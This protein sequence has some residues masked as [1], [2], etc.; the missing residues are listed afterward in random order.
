[1]VWKNV[2]SALYGTGDVDSAGPEDSWPDIERVFTEWAFEFDLGPVVRCDHIP[3]GLNLIAVPPHMPLLLE[4]G[5]KTSK[6]WRGS[7]LFVLEDLEPL[8]EMDPRGFRCVRK[9]A[10]GLLK[11]VLNGVAWGGRPNQEG[12]LQKNVLELLH[13]DPEGMRLAG[14]LFGPAEKTVLAAAESFAG[15]S[16][17]QRSVLMTEGWAFLRA[18]AAPVTMI[19]RIRFRLTAKARCPIVSVLLGHQRRIPTDREAWLRT[20]AESHTVHMPGSTARAG[21]QS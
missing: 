16:W 12:L 14:R 5:V 1:M 13:A 2:E 9:G 19:E 17:D 8:A 18:L 3:G 6:S 21:G 4:L 7:R 15:G 11:F 20:V 10:E